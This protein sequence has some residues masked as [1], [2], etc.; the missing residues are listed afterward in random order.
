MSALDSFSDYLLKIN[1]TPPTALKKL[2]GLFV[3]VSLK[4]HEFYAKQG[5][6]PKKIAF[7]HQGIMRIFF[8]NQQGEEFNKR[9][10]SGP[11]VIGAYSS[12][13]TNQPNQVN[14]QCLTDCEIIEAN[15]T[16]ILTLYDHHHDVERLNRKIT[17]AFF[18]E[19]EKRQM[20]LIMYDAAERYDKFRKEFPDYENQIA[21]YHIAS[22]LGITPTQL[23]R[24]RAKKQTK[25]I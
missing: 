14:I 23:S 21:Q 18:I 20:S 3:P 11:N 25:A 22:Y 7:I 10:V 1:P 6:R 17:E 9:F 16:E 19:T 12:L 2:L 4:K 15:F 13:L 24:I 8:Q 5:D